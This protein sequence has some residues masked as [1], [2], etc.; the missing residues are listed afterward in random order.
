MDAAEIT[1]QR[2]LRGGPQFD[3]GVGGFN[4]LRVGAVSVMTGG[5]VSTTLTV[6]VT[7]VAALPAASVTS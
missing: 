3:V 4:G 1:I 7:V 5:V 6:R 2:V